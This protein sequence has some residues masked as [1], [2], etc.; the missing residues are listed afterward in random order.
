[1]NGKIGVKSKPALGSNFWF[2]LPLDSPSEETATTDPPRGVPNDCL[3]LIVDDNRESRTIMERY[4]Q[5]W[6]IRVETNGDAAASLARLERA[7]EQGTTPDIVFV[8]LRLPSMDGWQL[9]SEIRNDHRFDKIP[10]VLMSPTGVSSG[11]AKMKLLRWFK[12]YINKPV[13]PRELKQAFEAVFADDIE[14]LEAVDTDGHAAPAPLARDTVTLPETVLVAEDHFVN[15]QL[16]QTILEKRG[17]RT[18][19]A[20]DGSEAVEAVQANPEIGLIFMDVQMPNLNGYDATT[21]IRELG[22]D[23]PIVAVTA[24]ALS[25]DRDRCVR[26][27]MNEYMSKPFKKNDIDAVLE[28][29]K[30]AGFFRAADDLA[31]DAQ[32]VSVLEELDADDVP[33]DEA[34]GEVST[35]GDDPP[36]DID[37]TVEAFMG[38]G[39][40]AARVSR[41]FAEKLPGQLA[42]V[43][44]FIEA[45]KMTDAR[46]VIHAVKGGA[47]NL[48]CPDLGEAARIVEDDCAA[49]RGDDALAHL[50]RV[51]QEAERYRSFIATAEFPE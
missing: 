17:F 14:E 10:L 45:E 32:L 49:D 46:I 24:N 25:G 22:I 33:V 26:V 9:A 47:W 1:M 2:T 23:T 28:R 27:G 5:R 20:S 18:L 15:Q 8:D 21:K 38:D 31:D 39:A 30:T 40:T 48:N 42:E 29:L 4:L 11:D 7:V 50:E 51:R 43:V 19:V 36:M 35:P 6:G 16:F 41:K 3:C 44:N 34:V 12:A 37:A 13:K